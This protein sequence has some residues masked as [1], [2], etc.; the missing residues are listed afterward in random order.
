MTGAAIVAMGRTDRGGTVEAPIYLG[1]V[2]PFVAYPLLGPV[3]V[4]RIGWVPLWSRPSSTSCRSALRLTTLRQLRPG[5][6]Q[7]RDSEHTADE[8]EGSDAGSGVCSSE[9]RRRGEIL[10]DGTYTLK[11]LQLR[12]DQAFVFLEVTLG[13]PRAPWSS[14]GEHE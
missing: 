8:D 3:Y 6:C 1:P 10:L 13:G 5:S 14:H 12:L 9:L 4:T 2:R 7:I 11:S